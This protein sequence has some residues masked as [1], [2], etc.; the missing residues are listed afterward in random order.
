[1]PSKICEH[2][3]QKH[4][5]RDC[6]GSAFCEHNKQKS[7]CRACKGSEIC[8]HD[9]RKSRCRECKGSQI[10]EHNKIK[11]T[12]RDCRGS[13]FC[14][15]NKNKRYCKSCGGS[16]LCKSSWCDTKA[17]KKYENYCMPCFVNNP[18]N[19]DKLPSRNHKT[20]ET[21]VVNYIRKTYHAFDF[22]ADKRVKD[23]CSSRRPDVLLDLGSHIIIIE[24][25]ENK[26]S[27]YEC[28]C[29][30]K[31]LMQLSQDL[32]HRPI[33]FI[34]FNPDSYID[35]NNKRVSSCWKLTKG[36]LSIAKKGEWINRLE[37]LK[38]QITYWIE[39]PS[40]KTVEIVELFY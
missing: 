14:E 4:Q 11:S 19:A 28:S 39:N 8:E 38:Q 6:K 36:V 35:V 24:V 30:N 34:R 27:N 37:T 22:V 26:H 21:E 13:A 9:K 15:H 1:M 18:L 10:C 20:K 31:R 17:S 3:R 25:D 29:E 32:Q 2:G 40:D 12:C 23:G 5:C 7:K 16:Q 33:V